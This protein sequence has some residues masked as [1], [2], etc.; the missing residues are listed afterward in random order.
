VYL[1]RIVS[2]NARQELVYAIEASMILAPGVILWLGSEPQ[3][4]YPTPYVWK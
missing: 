2:L 4:Y 3:F 1:L